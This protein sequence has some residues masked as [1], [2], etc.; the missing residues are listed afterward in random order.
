MKLHVWNRTPLES[1]IQMIPSNDQVWVTQDNFAAQ[2]SRPV[3]RVVLDDIKQEVNATLIQEWNHLADVTCNGKTITDWLQIDGQSFWHYYKFKGYFTVREWRYEIQ[4]LERYT[5]DF[6]EITF[7]T[8]HK[9]LSE[10]SWPTHVRIVHAE[11]KKNEALPAAFSDFMRYAAGCFLKS[12]SLKKIK[13]RNLIINKSIPQ[14]IWNLEMEKWEKGNVYLQRVIDHP[15]WDGICISDTDIPPLKGKQFVSHFAPSSNSIGEAILFRS[16]INPFHLWRALKVAKL[17]KARLNAIPTN[18][19]SRTEQLIFTFLKQEASSSSLFALKFNAW[20]SALKKH[21]PKS[22]VLIDENSPLTR[23]VVDAARANDIPTFAL[24][25]GSIHEQ[26]PAYMNAAGDS[27]R[28][29][30]PDYTLV[31]GEHWK[32]VLTNKGNHPRDRI[33]VVGQQRTDVIF[34][35][36]R[37]Q[38]ALRKKLINTDQP[39]ILFATQPQQD[40]Q[41][42]MRAAKDVFTALRNNPEFK[43]ILKLH[44]AEKGDAPFYQGIALEVGCSNYELK[45]DEDLYV[46][47]AAADV[48]ITAFST[49][50]TEAVYFKKPIIIWDPLHQ[51]LLGLIK[52][53]LAFG[54]TDSESISKAL[55]EILVNGQRKN[56]SALDQFIR[57]YVYQLDG[58]TAER[59]CDFIESHSK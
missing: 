19:F 37:H 42:R 32:N 51:D 49:V 18:D 58:K 29:V 30:F 16:L 2:F 43:G 21:Q 38:E 52:L 1:E 27:N 56:E 11:T 5:Q 35:L 4:F 3:E 17:L 12:G 34:D 14:N 55:H 25:H 33:H 41:M 44:P 39:K 47:L 50:G 8:R 57:E 7:Y 26:H 36:L 10:M 23:C 24:Q 59:I 20:K 53:D 6:E 46:L 48:V 28:D 9:Q 40:A 54:V 13:G 45:S 31:W 22:I 15:R